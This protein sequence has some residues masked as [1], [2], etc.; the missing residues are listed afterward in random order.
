M[1]TLDYGWL[2]RYYQVLIQTYMLGLWRLIEV[3][4]VKSCRRQ[5]H[6]LDPIPLLID[7]VHKSSFIQI[8]I[9]LYYFINSFILE[10]LRSYYYQ[11]LTYKCKT[12]FSMKKISSKASINICPIFL[13][14]SINKK[15]KLQIPSIQ[16]WIKH[17][18]K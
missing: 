12:N 15:I 17:S 5:I 4:S 14:P 10:N 3:Y 9:Y 18:Q 6:N 7:I 11:L 16:P 13:N 8:I 1:K 2:L